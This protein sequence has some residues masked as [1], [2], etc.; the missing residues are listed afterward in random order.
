MKKVVNNKLFMVSLISDIISD[1]GDILFYL[2]LMNYVLEIDSGKMEASISIVSLSEAIP[3]FI[4]FIIGNYADKRKYKVQGIINS[5]IFR[6]LLYIILAV[7]LIKSPTFYIL[8]LASLINLIS[9]ISGLY[10][11]NLNSFVL[12]YIVKNEDRES[13]MAFR[14][15]IK[16]S[17]TLFFKFIGGILIMYL[18]YSGLALLNA[19]TFAISGIIFILIKDKI[20]KLVP[21]NENIMKSN[22]TITIGTLTKDLLESIK[23]LFSLKDIKHALLTL[24]FINGLAGIFHMIFIMLLNKNDNMIIYSTE[25]TISLFFFIMSIGSI[26]GSILSVKEFKRISLSKLVT[27]MICMIL[28][29]FIS[30]INSSVYMIMILIFINSIIEGILNPKLGAIIINN[31]P[32]DKIGTVMGGMVTYFTI[33][34][35]IFRFLFS[36][37][38]LYISLNNIIYMYLTFAIILLIYSIGSYLYKK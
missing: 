37:V 27:I 14:E 2:A 18:S 28:F 31:L 8:V 35:L 36:L 34:D 21:N 5:L 12:K 38:V 13:T 32:S 22:S 20:L 9:D 3:L 1:F 10:E 7:F 30:F 17:L 16:E 15:S 25:F 23:Y 11:N 4:A 24:P 33:G 26:F 19:S 6:F 29:I